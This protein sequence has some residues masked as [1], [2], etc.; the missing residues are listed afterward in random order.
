MSMDPNWAAEHLQVIRTLMERSA[1]YRRALG[2]IMLLAGCIGLGGA[3]LGWKLEF[4]R[5]LVFIAFWYA[6]GMA[7]LSGA[8]VM[9]RRQALKSAE[10]VWSPPTRRVAQALLPALTAGFLIG[11][12]VAVSTTRLDRPAPGLVLIGLPLIWV[13]LYGCGLHAAGFFML[14][15]MRWFGWGLIGLG[16][17]ACLT[18]CPQSAGAA[19]AWAYG[20]MGFFF[21]VLHLAYGVYLLATEKRG[22]AL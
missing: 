15:G 4:Y 11:V 7:V 6:C 5:P 1:V 9:V 12:I 2:P 16:C 17:A 14:R 8:F 21:G 20:L 18:A 3:L 22:T 10:P 13:V 19:V